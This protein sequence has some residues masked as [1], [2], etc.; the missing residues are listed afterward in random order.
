M[1]FT[2]DNLS[3]IVVAF[4]RFQSPCRA[5]EIGLHTGRSNLCPP[6]HPIA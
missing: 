3:S 2:F 6:P 5:V 1:E 4:S